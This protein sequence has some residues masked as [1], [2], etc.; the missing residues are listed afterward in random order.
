MVENGL[1]SALEERVKE[2]E[3]EVKELKQEQVKNKYKIDSI[4]KEITEIKESINRIPSKIDEKN[5]IQT[6]NLTCTF[7][8]LLTDAV[9]RSDK[10]RIKKLE[11]YQG[12]IIKA[13]L[14]T[15]ITIIIG[16]FLARM[17]VV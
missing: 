11:D 5:D 15:V 16:A 7:K 3:E 10:E 9:Q 1:I 13:V 2:L 6:D 4:N 17:G 12:W 14:G 8:Q